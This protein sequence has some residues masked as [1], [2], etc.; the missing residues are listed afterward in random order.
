VLV[1]RK[2]IPVATRRRPFAV[3]MILATIVCA[4]APVGDA[5]GQLPSIDPTGQR[6]FA[7]PSTPF[8]PE[9]ASINYRNTTGISVVP[10]RIAAPVGTEVVMLA[11]VC[12]QAGYLMANERVE[13][14]LS[15]GG[16]GQFVALGDRYPLDWL[17]GISGSPKKVDNSL[18]IGTTSSRYVTLTRGTPTPVDDVQVLKGQAWITVTSP[19][20]GISYVTAYAPSVYGWDRRKQ[21]AAIYWIDAQ[22]TFPPPANAPVGSRRALTTS[23]T[24]TSNGAPLA[25]W[26]VRYE[27]SGAPTA[28]FAPDGGPVVEIVSNAQGQA[29]AELFQQQPA[30]GGTSVAIQVIRPAELGGSYG[31]R[32]VAG[33]GGSVTS[34]TTASNVSAPVASPQAPIATGQAPIATGPAPTLAPAPLAESAPTQAPAPSQPPLQSPSQSAA[35]PVPALQLSMQGPRTANVGDRVTFTATVTNRGSTPASDLIVVD[36]FDE[37]LEHAVHAS[38]IEQPIVALNPGQFRRINVTLRVTKAGELCN[39][40]EIHGPGGTKTSARGCVTAVAGAGG[41]AAA[42]GATTGVPSVAVKKIG[43]QKATVGQ[44]AEFSIEVTNTGQTPLT[45]LKIVDH[46]DGALNPKNATDGFTAEGDDLVWEIAS[47]PPGKTLRPPIRVQCMCLKPAARACN[48]AIVT[49]AEGARDTSEACLE[50]VAAA[51]GGAAPE[52][53]AAPD[54]GAA[55]KSDAPARQSAARPQGAPPPGLSMQVVDL[56]E[57]VIVGKD[58]LIDVRVTN[59]SPSP[60]RQLAL[61]VRLSPEATP[62]NVGTSGPAPS[63]IEGQTVRFAPVAE[64]RPHETLKYQIR[65]RANN[66]GEARAQARLTSAAAIAAIVAD[67]TAK[68]VAE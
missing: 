53:G 32:I 33:I 12:G 45:R 9:P 25:G 52:Q 67:G 41:A 51:A 65:V 3:A 59:N 68:I 58:T 19:V 47:L 2:I 61:V 15:P 7:W 55:S 17:Q 48:Q 64:I 28:G 40:I 31:Q 63:T 21:T 4:L 35:A 57:P 24:R 10:A 16:V 14:M 11:A 37:G 42:G 66:P 20:E 49:T 18:A 50:I 36:R 39:V 29:T 6:I 13:W 46:F 27:V 43:P 34:W 1:L 60:D 62:L 22:W 54:K 44:M 5:R 38:P 23:L 30:P 56:G 26:L 8:R